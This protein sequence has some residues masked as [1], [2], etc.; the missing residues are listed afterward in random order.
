MMNGKADHLAA[1]LLDQLDAR[2]GGPPRR[3]DVVVDQDTL[4]CDDRVRVHLQRVESV[5]EGRTWP[6]R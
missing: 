1:E 2:L 3:E 6:Q 4:P 5:L